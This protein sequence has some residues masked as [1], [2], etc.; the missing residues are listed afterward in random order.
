MATKY[1]LGFF[2]QEYES[3]DLK[4]RINWQVGGKERVPL[5]RSQPPEVPSQSTEYQAQV[6]A[7]DVSRPTLMLYDQ[8]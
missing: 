6:R 4:L 7:L 5:I 1:D 8:L 2:P 3:P